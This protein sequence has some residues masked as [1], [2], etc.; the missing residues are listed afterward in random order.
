MATPTL[1]PQLAVLL[2]AVPR[3]GSAVAVGELIT[4]TVVVTNQGAVVNQLL[5]TATIPL[6]TDYVADSAQPPSGAIAAGLTVNGA[7]AALPWRLASLA[8]GASFRATYQVRVRGLGP[9]TNHAAVQL[10]GNTLL[11]SN[12][13]LHQGVPPKPTNL[14]PEDEPR[15]YRVYLPAVQQNR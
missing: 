1:V 10:V 14:L 6:Q 15:P 4:Y 7:T 5:I 12:A 13:V 3:P 2:S 8:P 11:L 9:L